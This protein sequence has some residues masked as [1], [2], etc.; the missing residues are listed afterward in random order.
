MRKLPPRSLRLCLNVPVHAAD[1]RSAIEADST[2]VWLERLAGSRHL[3]LN[4]EAISRL[5][6]DPGEWSHV[7]R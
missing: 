1:D 5:P 2:D 6:V 3:L 4:E 7:T